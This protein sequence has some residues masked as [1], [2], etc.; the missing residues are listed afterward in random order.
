[1]SGSGRLAACAMLALIGSPAWA[2]PG[3]HA[4]K[5]LIWFDL[6]ETR[7]GEIALEIDTRDYVEKQ[8]RQDSKEP[9]FKVKSVLTGTYDEGAIVVRGSGNNCVHEA[10]AGTAT[11]LVIVGELLVLPSGE[12]QLIPRYMSYD[13]PIRVAAAARSVGERN[14]Q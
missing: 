13:D 12:R 7:P 3:P 5:Y 4:E 2:C 14:A 10:A 6:P 8:Q 1:M 11:R 9:V